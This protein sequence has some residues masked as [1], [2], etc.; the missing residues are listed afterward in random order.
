MRICVVMRNPRRAWRR[1]HPTFDCLHSLQALAGA[2]CGFP[3]STP[4]AATRALLL[5]IRRPE[6][7]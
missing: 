4:D 6:Q 1:I 2:V 7:G 5:T 3:T